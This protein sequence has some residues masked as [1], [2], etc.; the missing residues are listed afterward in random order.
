MAVPSLSVIAKLPKFDLHSHIDGSIPVGELFRI[1][2]RN[3]RKI[4]TSKGTE[5]DTPDAFMRL[6]RGSGYHGLLDE[7]VER[8]HPITG[9]MQTSQI[10]RDIGI[11]YVEEQRRHNVIYAEGRFAPQY[12]TR[13]GLSLR[14]VVRSMK[15]GLEEGSERFGVRA[16][17]IVAF[18]RESS[19]STAAEVAKAAVGIEGVVALDVGGPEA[20][21][22]AEK[23]RPAFEIADG[24]G[25]KKTVHAGEGA[26]SLEQNLRNIRSAI[27]ILGADRVGHAVDIAKDASLIRLAASRGVA[28]EMNPVSNVT[29]RKIRSPSELE[30]DRLLDDSVLVTLN[31]D[32]PA[33]WP[34]GSIDEVIS[35]V[36]KAYGFGLE[37]IDRFVANSIYGSFA[38]DRRKDEM[39]EDYRAVRETLA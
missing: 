24:G 25:L 26:E 22:P 19:T 20:Y 2:K 17:L 23:F 1:A 12:H 9:L 4:F 29:L 28:I 27:T 39:A 30:I 37:T 8:F 6:V 13:E 33:L 31:T 18:G 5:V 10:I 34:R 36:C 14:E 32:D 7:I 35:S 38:D 11:S 15:E 3:K 16:N 21:H